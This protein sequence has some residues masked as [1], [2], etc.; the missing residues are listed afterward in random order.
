[1]RVLKEHGYQVMLT[2]HRRYGLNFAVDERV[3]RAADEDRRLLLDAVQ[4]HPLGQIEVASFKSMVEAMR[5]IIHLYP[6]AH[7]LI[8]VATKA[9]GRRIHRQLN[10]GPM[11]QGVRLIGTS[12]PSTPCRCLVTTFTPMFAANLDPW[13]IILLPEIRGAVSDW[14]VHAMGGTFGDYTKVAHRIYSFRLPHVRLGRRDSLRLEVVS[15]EVIHRRGPQYAGVRVLWLP[16][17]SCPPVESNEGLEYKRLAYWNNGR[18]NDYIATVARAFV[19]RDGHK[20]STYGIPY[21]NDE[22]TLRHYPH[23]KLVML[24]ESPE[25]G[26]QMLKRLPAWE[27]RDAVPT[28]TPAPIPTTGILPDGWIVTSVRAVQEPIPADIIIYAAGSQGNVQ[29]RDFP[30]VLNDE[31][32]RDVIVVDFRDRFDARA[33]EDTSRRRRQYERVGWEEL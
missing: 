10:D 29:V 28:R 6:K 9:T 4:N 27:Y 26:R 16:T 11:D 24:V 14:G 22:P 17:P 21:D 2:D 32:G 13:E 30:P 19:N 3:L 7:V 20:L 33:T 15:G 18:R 8:P 23:S 31:E 25:H 5:S 1:M 12:W